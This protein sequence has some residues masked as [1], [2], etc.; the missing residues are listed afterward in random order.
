MPVEYFHF[1]CSI[2]DPLMMMKMKYKNHI[3]VK[4]MGR[5]NILKL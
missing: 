2:L 4:I 5:E 1:K 3:K